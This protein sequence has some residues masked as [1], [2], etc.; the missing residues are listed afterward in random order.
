MEAALAVLLGILMIGAFV[1]VAIWVVKTLFDADMPSTERLIWLAIILM[2]PVV[3]AL[4]WL[5]WGQE[6]LRT[7]YSQPGPRSKRATL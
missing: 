6:S 3:G 1:A 5:S 4:I 7:R 2:F